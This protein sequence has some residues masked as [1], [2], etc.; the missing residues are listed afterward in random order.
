LF[1]FELSDKY[2]PKYSSLLQDIIIAFQSYIR[3]HR[4]IQQNKLWKWIIIPGIIYM[5]IFMAGMY[6]F[7]I[8]ADGAVSY[9]SDKI[10]I[11][12][13]LSRKSNEFLSFL[14]LMGGI[15]VR[16]VLVFFYFSLFKYL[17]LIVGS[18][19]FAYLS[20][21]TA[22]IIEKRDF[23]FSISQLMKDILRGIRLALR[24]T[25]WQ[26]VFLISIIILSLFPLVGW[27]TPLLVLFIEC[28]YFGFSMLDY[29]SERNKLSYGESINFI[30]KN[31][32]LAIGNGI[33]F[34]CMHLVPFVGWMFAPCYAVIAGTLSLHAKFGRTD[35]TSTD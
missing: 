33:V 24:N 6:Y 12:R 14:F 25:F 22:A 17:F 28:Y 21:K 13:W 11:D 2:K 32:G 1:K 23:P 18:P 4:F 29:N 10:G 8:S 16:I 15:M 20:E 27:I 31:K 34:Y 35:I 26:T 19:L 3:A 9:I 30:N 5:I 7:I